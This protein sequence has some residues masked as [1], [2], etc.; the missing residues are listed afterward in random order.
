MTPQNESE[1]KKEDVILGRLVFPGSRGYALFLVGIIPMLFAVWNSPHQF[2][3]KPQGSILGIWPL[4]DA[5]FILLVL[6]TPAA[7]AIARFEF[8]GKKAD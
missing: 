2:M 6:G 4:F 1:Q 5:P 7:W 3:V 8:K